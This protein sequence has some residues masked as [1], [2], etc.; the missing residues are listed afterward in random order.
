[1]IAADVRPL[2]TVE[3]SVWGNARVDVPGCYALLGLKAFI[4]QQ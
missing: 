3:F 2:A 1:M 4:A